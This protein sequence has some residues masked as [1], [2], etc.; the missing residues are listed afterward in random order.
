[1][2][3][4]RRAVRA[5]FCV[6]VAATM[7]LVLGFGVTAAYA[8]GGNGSS[9]SAFGGFADSA[10]LHGTSSEG[11]AFGSSIASDVREGSD[12]QEGSGSSEGF[13]SGSG[14]ELDSA[15]APES[16]ITVLAGTTQFDTS[17]VQALY[18]YPDG[19]RVAI[20]ASG[21]VPADALCAAPLAGALDCP[22]LLAERNE[23]SA[24]VQAALSEL[25]VEEVL[26][27]GGESVVSKEVESQLPEAVK[28]V[29]RISG[30]SQYDTQVE[31]FRY[32]KARG[33]W[34]E[35]NTVI[36]VSGNAISAA[37]AL[38]ISPYAFA[39]KTPVFF[40]DENGRIPAV[41]K[42]ALV[43]E[44]VCTQ[45]VIVGG[46]AVVSNVAQGFLEGLTWSNAGASNIVR[47]AGTTLYDTSAA[48]AE[49]SVASGVLSWEGAAFAT[50]RVPFDSLGGCV[51]QG[52]DVAVLLLADE[53][54][55]APLNVAARHKGGA[56]RMKFF[57]GEAVMP[58][59]LRSALAE[60]L[61]V[62]AFD[63]PDSSE[64]DSG[65]GDAG[66]GSGAGLGTDAGTDA[67]VDAKGG[68]SA[69]ALG[70]GAGDASDSD[71]VSSG[72]T[73]GASSKG[74]RL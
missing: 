7:V 14:S 33:F 62:K 43:N 12:S 39:T 66:S 44:T 70:I 3:S 63:E 9:A 10:A 37:D 58:E 40:A 60:A 67:G 42:I 49:W 57:G 8:G 34:G 71:S 31:V 54:E 28:K 11:D 72:D 24:S 38:S 48:V 45:A 30:I 32:G 17:A 13:D 65:A 15:S 23:L 64:S 35:A 74:S 29:E 19:A 2:K 73:D 27:I 1:M 5:G 25:G 36:V 56:K 26:I 50:G 4:G 53:G 68:S 20:V 59:S 22:I 16:N 46:T 41:E 51:V 47:L 69:D 55:Q 61:G 18:A 21:V 6:G 52:K